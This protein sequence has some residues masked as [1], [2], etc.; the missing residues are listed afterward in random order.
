VKEDSNNGDT[1]VDGK[2]AFQSL[3]NIASGHSKLRAVVGCCEHGDEPSD[4]K[5]MRNF[6]SS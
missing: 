5:I 1:G 4:Y 3:L 2:M 6:L